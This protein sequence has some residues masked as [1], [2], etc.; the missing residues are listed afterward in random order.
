MNTAVNNQSKMLFIF[1][2][3]TPHVYSSSISQCTL[4]RNN[5][6]HLWSKYNNGLS[7]IRHLQ[8]LT[9][10]HQQQSLSV[11]SKMSQLPQHSGVQTS[12]ITSN[13]PTSNISSTDGRALCVKQG[14]T[15]PIQRARVSV[16]VSKSGVQ[17]CVS[18]EEDTAQTPLMMKRESTV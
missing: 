11:A 5:N 1:Q 17:P 6:Q 16:G 15:Q 13:I 10:V 8:P 4:P 9:T 7:G 18:D 3:V 12:A 14:G 2:N